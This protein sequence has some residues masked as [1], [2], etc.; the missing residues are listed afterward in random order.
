MLISLLMLNCKV[1]CCV[2]MWCVSNYLN[3][4][5]L[6]SYLYPGCVVECM[7]L[8]LFGVEACCRYGI[9]SSRILCC[10]WKDEVAVIKCN[11]MNC[12][13]FLYYVMYVAP[14]LLPAMVHPACSWLEY[15]E[16]IKVH[17]PALSNVYAS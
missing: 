12:I 11:M 17:V 14:T 15:R 4:C 2:M 5:M 8:Q 9:L 13:L 3:K 7:L 1:T 6:S 16:G 10:C